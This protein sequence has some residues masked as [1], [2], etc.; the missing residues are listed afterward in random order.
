MEK[1]QE[2]VDEISFEDNYNYEKLERYLV[3][4]VASEYK[5]P[6]EET[7]HNREKYVET[8]REGLEEAMQHLADLGYIEND[9]F[10]RF[11][12]EKIVP[13]SIN[14]ALKSYYK[15]DVLLTTQYT[16]N[17]NFGS[18]AFLEFLP[19]LNERLSL[20]TS[21]DGEFTH[22]VK[23][24][25]SDKNLYSRT[26]HF[27]LRLL[28]LYDEDASL[29][30]SSKSLIGAYKLKLLLGVLTHVEYQQHVQGKEIANEIFNLTGNVYAILNSFRKRYHANLLY[31]FFPCPDQPEA[32]LPYV[33]VHEEKLIYAK[34]KDSFKGAMRDND[35]PML[36]W[37]LNKPELTMY[38]D[39]NRFGIRLIQT[40]LWMNGFYYG[41]VDGAIGEVTYNALLNFIA[42]DSTK[43][44]SEYMVCMKEMTWAVNFDALS[45]QMMVYKATASE[46]DEEE[47]LSEQAE[48]QVITAATEQVQKEAISRARKF[49]EDI[50]RVA[51]RVYYGARSLIASALKGIRNVWHFIRDELIGPVANFFRHLL[52]QIRTGIRTFFDGMKRFIH[53]LLKKP[54][55]TVQESGFIVSKFDF[56]SDGMLFTNSVDATAL[57]T[58]HLNLQAKLTRQVNIFMKVTG[59]VI[60]MILSMIPP[61]GW[62]KLA[63]KIGRVIIDVVRN[64]F[65]R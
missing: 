65:K 3:T 5:V 49:F 42:A 33:F 37:S 2:L 19:I 34:N 51:R 10:D 43:N 57:L 50:K 16:V 27:R 20:L 38:T 14:E 6:Y 30:I 1:L 41:R 39:E 35:A 48:P 32:E 55:I 59:E 64:K 29:P 52:K 4:Q 62:I 18:P 56:D 15:D 40:L 21:L 54:L 8:E 46:H 36:R 13:D 9:E 58:T 11:A 17:A 7:D 63:L 61:L 22:K 45:E 12:Q 28:G 31:Y 53:F 26:L 47:E 24:R 44:R 60:G 23:F 25:I